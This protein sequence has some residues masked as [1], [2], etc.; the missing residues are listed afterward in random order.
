MLIAAYTAAKDAVKHLNK[1]SPRRKLMESH[2]VEELVSRITPESR[3]KILQFLDNHQQIQNS[4]EREKMSTALNSVL[5]KE[6]L[7]QDAASRE[8]MLKFMSEPMLPY[9][10]APEE[11]E[12]HN[13]NLDVRVQHI[14]SLTAMADAKLEVAQELVSANFTLRVLDMFKYSMEKPTVLCILVKALRALASQ[15]LSVEQMLLPQYEFVPLIVSF[16]RSKDVS[17][18][19]EASALVALLTIVREMVVALKSANI[20]PLLTSVLSSPMAASEQAVFNNGIVSLVRIIAVS[21]DS[22]AE[23]LK[24][25]QAVAPLCNIVTRLDRT[26]LVHDAVVTLLTILAGSP[27]I[28]LQIVASGAVPSLCTMLVSYADFASGK[29]SERDFRRITTS[30]ATSSAN[31]HAVSTKSALS[32]EE[33]GFVDDDDASDDSVNPIYR[34][35]DPEDIIPLMRLLSRVPSA[36]AQMLENGQV[37]PALVALISNSQLPFSQKTQA[38]NALVNF[39]SDTSAQQAVVATEVGRW[40]AQQTLELGT[41]A[42]ELVFQSHALAVLALFSTHESI[43]KHIAHKFWLSAV[44]TRAPKMQQQKAVQQA[45]ASILLNLL[46]GERQDEIREIIESSEPIRSTIAHMV[47]EDQMNTEK[48]SIWAA[49]YGLM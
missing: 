15:E 39:A 4:E 20:V 49:V 44:V 34:G 32:E 47:R 26:P 5:L 9:S 28:S 12:L 6:Q 1:N 27:E 25:A 21:G 46:R 45:I 23:D 13:R 48:R 14:V 2:S 19:V 22:I 37:L 36:R 41:S 8:E 31:D 3:A 11:L 30:G 35:S 33:E 29:L 7:E 43:Q 42:E 40:L 10:S 18:R 16:L 17:L 24:K 38:T